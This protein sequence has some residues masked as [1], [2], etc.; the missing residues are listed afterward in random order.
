M[1]DQDKIDWEDLQRQDSHCDMWEF[2]DQIPNQKFVAVDVETTG[3]NVYNEDKIMGVSVA[4]RWRGGSVVSYYFPFNHKLGYNLSD[5]VRAA[6]FVSLGQT[7]PVFH[8]GGFDLQAF[9]NSYGDRSPYPYGTFFYDSMYIAHLLDQ[10]IKTY[11]LDALSKRILHDTGKDKSEL[12]DNIIKTFGWAMVPSMVM[13]K[14]GQKDAELT[15]RLMEYFMGQFKR[16]EQEGVW[17]EK[18]KTVWSLISLGRNGVEV[19]ETKCEALYEEG[20]STMQEMEKA[21]KC[22]PGS[23]KEL[24]RLLITELGLPVVKRTNTGKPSFDKYAME[25]YEEILSVA[26]SPVAKQILTYRGWQKASSTYYKAFLEKR[27][28]DGKLRP[29]FKVTGTVTGR[30]S[31]TSPNLQQIPK[32]GVQ[33]WNKHTKSCIVAPEGYTPIEFDYAQLELRLAVVYANIASLKEV[34]NEE[35]D[36]FIEMSSQM[37]YPRNMVKS[38]VYATQYGAKEQ[39]ISLLL[40]CSLADAQALSRNYYSSYP[41]FKKISDRVVD[42]AKRRNYIKYWTGRRRIFWPSEARKAWNSLMQGGGADIVERSLNRVVREYIGTDI[43]I[44]VLT[45]HDSILCYVKKGHEEDVK[46]NI[47][48]IMSDVELGKTHGVKFGVDAHV[49][50]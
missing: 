15:F 21:L 23:P 37:K 4:Y 1:T 20:I 46:K 3:L 44:P 35:R 9:Y 49:W 11:S 19:D 42:L 43:C 30:L 27:N 18:V 50:G 12:L 14:Y 26:N 17:V 24:E 47:L 32:T 45:V 39:K 40:G 29:N 33:P 8:N 2:I 31:C 36:L 7:V 5:S 41:E 34:F 25:E 28:I 16:T 13:V 22:N 48:N 6:L 10:R 38:F